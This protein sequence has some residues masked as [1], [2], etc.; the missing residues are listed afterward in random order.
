MT[1][2][3]TVTGAPGVHTIDVYPSVWWGNNTVYHKIPIEY[4]FPLLTPQDHPA[5]MPSFHFSF[6]I[7]GQGGTT[8]SSGAILPGLALP[9]L[10]FVALESGSPQSSLDDDVRTAGEAPKR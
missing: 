5:Q 3:L 6:L 7:T 2:Y 1:F 9:G 8:Q 4:D 10:A